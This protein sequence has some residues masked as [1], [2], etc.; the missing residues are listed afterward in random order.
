MD[1]IIK[2]KFWILSILV[3]P[4]ALAGFFMANGG[5]KTATAERVTQLEGIS[6]PNPNQPND[7][8]T[9]VAKARANEQEAANAA[10]LQLLDSIQRR[11]MNWP[12]LILDGLEVNPETGLLVYR[13]EKLRQDRIRVQYPDE[14]QKELERVWL[15]V[16][17]V[18]PSGLPYSDK[19]L[20]K[21]FCEPES[22]PFHTLTQTPTVQEIWDAQEDIW[23]MEMLFTAVNATNEAATDVNDAAIREIMYLELFGGTGDS[24]VTTA[25]AGPGSEGTIDYMSAGGPTGESGPGVPGSGAA[26]PFADGKIAYD[27]QMEYG[28]QADTAAVAVEGGDSASYMG[29]GLF[30]GAG[31]AGSKALRYIKFDPASPGDYRKRGFYISLL[32]QEKKIP[33]F[34]V[35][36]A[37]LDPPIY[38]GRWGFANNPNDTDHLLKA[39]F[40]NIGGGANYSGGEYESGAPG[41]G[42]GGGGRTPRRAPSRT[43]GSNSFGS[44]YSSGAT[45]SAAPGTGG[46]RSRPYTQVQMAE[47]VK[48][49]AARLGKDL[50]QLE[51]SGVVTIFTPNVPAL[52]APEATAE[53][54]PADAAAPASETTDTPVDPAAPPVD[55]AAAVPPTDPAAPPTDPAAAPSEPL[56]P[57]ATPPVDPSAAPPAVEPAPPPT[58]AAPPAE[59][60]PPVDPAAPPATP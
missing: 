53:A 39:G 35:A 20:K 37:N 42:G 16:N 2:Y 43:S 50:V 17:P 10:Q 45:G 21:V 29:G 55:P 32:I 57:Q 46:L 18:I 28:S 6:A 31:T 33:D 34:V 60:P 49:D 52:P 19:S 58:D 54:P 59:S 11:W 9:A 44:E 30:G 23:I 7:T 4:L 14:Y 56:P 38:A 47:L 26:V 40:A 27:P 5:I 8:H 13:G 24:T 3:L 12:Q 51:L 15:M 22:I 25:A 1:K 41:F 36:L 48:F